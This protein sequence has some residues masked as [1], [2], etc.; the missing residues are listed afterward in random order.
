VK[1]NLPLLLFSSSSRREEREKKKKTNPIG[2]S[3][4]PRE[5]KSFIGR[6]I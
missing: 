6:K 1:S 3:V 5:R 4:E 2:L